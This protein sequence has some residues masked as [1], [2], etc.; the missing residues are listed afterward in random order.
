[1]ING[2]I[3]I[4]FCIILSQFDTVTKVL[5]GE[6]YPTFA[7]AFPYLCLMYRGCLRN[8]HLFDEGSSDLA[9]SLKKRVLEFQRI[10]KYE[11]Y[12]DGVVDKLK[13]IQNQL[14]I[15]FTERF[16]NLDVSMTWI[17][18]LDPRMRA[19]NHLNVAMKDRAKSIFVEEVCK[20]RNGDEN[21]N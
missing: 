10:H 18:F 12:Y 9:G 3:L 7:F 5:S 19:M 2:R 13:R 15:L 21:G 20:V 16:S 8:K 17:S 14:A 4:R 1:M 6:K 11:A